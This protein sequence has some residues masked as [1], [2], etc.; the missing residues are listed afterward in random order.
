MDDN[1]EASSFK[2]RLFLFL[3]NI[4]CES[5][6]RTIVSSPELLR[7]DCAVRL[8]V[9]HPEADEGGAGALAR[10]LQDHGDLG[11]RGEEIRA[12]L[13]DFATKMVFLPLIMGRDVSEISLNAV[14]PLNSIHTCSDTAENIQLP[15]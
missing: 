1:Q 12:S 15:L 14:W 13:T 9:Q 2:K 11:K 10:A 4:R 3:E 5:R 7:G 6:V 8:Q